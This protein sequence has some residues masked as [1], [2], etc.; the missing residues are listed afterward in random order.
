MIF[1]DLLQ[2]NKQKPKTAKT[3]NSHLFGYV[4]NVR[5]AF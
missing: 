3:E 1:V 2:I 5:V 4:L